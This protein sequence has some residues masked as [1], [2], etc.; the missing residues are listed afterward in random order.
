MKRKCL[1]E[2]VR[3]ISLI[4]YCSI[5]FVGLRTYRGRLSFLPVRPYEPRRMNR[6]YS[7]AES[8]PNGTTS[9]QASAEESVIVTQ[10][11]MYIV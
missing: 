7:V 10:P 6:T 1:G 5:S 2:G 8:G 3:I 11:G 4:M 9:P